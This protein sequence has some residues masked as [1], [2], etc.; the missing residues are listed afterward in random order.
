MTREEL[1]NELLELYKKKGTARNI[2]SLPKFTVFNSE[3]N[4][5]LL[6]NYRFG[7][8]SLNAV[9]SKLL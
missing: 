6:R 3:K 7:N 9:K 1:A 4:V 5:I 8:L 2:L